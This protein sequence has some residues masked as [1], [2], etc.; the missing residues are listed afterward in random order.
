MRSLSTVTPVMCA[1]TA[2][3]V[4]TVKGEKEVL[5]VTPHGH[6]T[7]DVM[8]GIMKAHDCEVITCAQGLSC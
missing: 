5:K 4:V 7:E 2:A 3:C 6:V 1:G 8:N